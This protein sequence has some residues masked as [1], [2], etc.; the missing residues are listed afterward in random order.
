MSF[1]KLELEGARLSVTPLSDSY[2]GLD[3]ESCRPRAIKLEGIGK[4]TSNEILALFFEIRRRSGGGDIEQ[5]DYDDDEGIVVIIF[6]DANSKY[7][8][9][10]LKIKHCVTLIIKQCVTLTKRLNIFNNGA[11]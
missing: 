10:W 11:D 8:H 3:R 6:N 5:F 7:I 2:Y 9:D 4:V 1:D